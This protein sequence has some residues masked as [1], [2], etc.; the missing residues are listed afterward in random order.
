MPLQF[1]VDV[2]VSQTIASEEL[3]VKHASKVYVRISQPA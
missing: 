2:Q 3:L 1:L